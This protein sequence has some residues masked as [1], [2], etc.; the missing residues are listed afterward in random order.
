VK[1]LLPAGFNRLEPGA[2]DLRLYIPAR[3]FGLFYGVADE[4]CF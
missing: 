3:F 1:I 2:Q 4:H